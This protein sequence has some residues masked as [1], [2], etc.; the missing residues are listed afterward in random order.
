MV[1]SLLFTEGLSNYQKTPKE[2]N[3][4]WWGS[5]KII[6]RNPVISSQGMEETAKQPDTFSGF[7]PQD[8]GKPDYIP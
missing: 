4:H 3:F 6:K 1:I 2:R 8:N 5:R 7:K